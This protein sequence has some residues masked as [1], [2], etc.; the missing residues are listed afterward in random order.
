M[1]EHDKMN[2]N[3][4][5]RKALFKEKILKIPLHKAKELKEIE[6]ESE[7]YAEIFESKGCSYSGTDL[8]FH[9][10]EKDCFHCA[11]DRIK[12]EERKKGLDWLDRT[13]VW[14]YHDYWYGKYGNNSF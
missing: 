12:K 4:F 13:E 7:L 1:C 10:E 11:Y 9:T 5:E 8:I 6:E 14:D 3:F 2:R